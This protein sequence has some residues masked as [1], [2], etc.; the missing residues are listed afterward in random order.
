MRL[1]RPDLQAV[2]ILARP[3]DHTG[4]RA[5][6]LAPLFPLGGIAAEGRHDPNRSAVL[7]AGG[8]EEN[9]AI[10]RGF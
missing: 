3:P 9:I 5:A 1:V 10:C 4:S 6:R 8:L 7:G 2:L